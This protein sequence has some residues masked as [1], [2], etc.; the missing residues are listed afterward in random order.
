M[1]EL[2]EVMVSLKNL[3]KFQYEGNDYEF[4]SYINWQTM[5][6]L[7]IFIYQYIKNIDFLTSSSKPALTS[8]SLTF[9][10]ASFANF[11]Q[12]LG[13]LTAPNLKRLQLNWD[14]R[15]I[16]ALT[17]FANLEE[18]RVGRIFDD[19]GIAKGTLFSLTSENSLCRNKIRILY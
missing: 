2:K 11:P 7:S 9:L 3:K 16:P 14:C 1:R 8:L 12:Q 15:T 4:L 18:L 13:Q 17:Q 19:P 6:K 10:S 5:E